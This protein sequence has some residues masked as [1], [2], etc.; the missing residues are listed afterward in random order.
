MTTEAF[1]FLHA[2]DFH[3]EQPLTGLAEVPQHLRDTI[4]DAP[5]TAALR[6]FDAAIREQADFL[7]LSGDLIDVERAGPRGLTFL[8]E[9][10]ER[11][12]AQGIAIYWAGGRTDGPQEWPTAATLPSSVQ[13]FPAFKSEQLTHFRGESPIA[14]LWGRS[15]H[16]SM[17]I[18]AADF[19]EEND[20]L[21]TI[22]IAHG[23]AD[24][25][26]LVQ[27]RVE[28]WALGGEHNRQ[29]FG[30][31]LRTIHL[32][33][34]PQGRSPAEIGPHGC[35][36]V[37]VSEEQKSRTQFIPTDA[38]RWLVESIA[39]GSEAG[40][41]ELRKLFSD[42]IKQLRIETEERPLLVKWIVRGGQRLL[43][44]SKRTELTTELLEW[45]RGEF[46]GSR[47]PLWSL[48]IEFDEA[49]LPA[50]HYA[51]DSMLG[52]FLRAV[53]DLETNENADLDLASL[54]TE[55][56]RA[57]DLAALADCSS[58]EVRQQILQDASILGARLLGAEER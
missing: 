44:T 33:G 2:S 48:A 43:S 56:Q 30:S 31:P 26:K 6:V 51:E 46:G 10:F 20:T 27:R 47:M 11:L 39:L 14:T 34:S 50:A 58:S 24:A 28:Y 32:P 15:F 4:V 54:L 45:L 55:R 38:I 53:R 17:S 40:K 36:L 16:G 29:T 22:A 5:Y 7:I 25:E 8:L 42:R 12:D 49:E 3:L 23:D 19:G 35:T 18:P 9:Q 41:T 37:H 57:N 52:D 21:F 1:R 13:V